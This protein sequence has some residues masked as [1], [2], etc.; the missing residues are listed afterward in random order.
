[1]TEMSADMTAVNMVDGIR[2]GFQIIGYV[3]GVAIL[4]GIVVA[5]GSGILGA[6]TGG[7]RSDGN[8]IMI[9]IGG[10]IWILGAS[11]IYAGFI[12][13]MYKMIADGVEKGT[14]NSNL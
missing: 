3:I 12:G 1:M 4:G 6:G 2:Y 5:I 10:G 9:L 11:I 7:L 8:P 13:S 14:Q